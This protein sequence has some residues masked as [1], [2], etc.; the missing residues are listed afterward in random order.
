MTSTGLSP[1]QFST[2]AA[3]ACYHEA[4]LSQ[5]VNRKIILVFLSGNLQCEFKGSLHISY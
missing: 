2:Q 3:K 5:P 4:K 1:S